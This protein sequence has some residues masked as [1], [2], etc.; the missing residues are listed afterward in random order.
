ML[1]RQFFQAASDLK[2]KRVMPVHNSKFALGKH[3]W[4]EPLKTINELG[5]NSQIPLLTPM[6]GEPLN[7]NNTNQTFSNWWNG[8]K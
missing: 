8:Q 6:I 4:F 2:A 1:P 3:A 5:K 7:I